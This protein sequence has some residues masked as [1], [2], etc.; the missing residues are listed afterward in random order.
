MAAFVYPNTR[1]EPAT[2]SAAGRH[3]PHGPAPYLPPQFPEGAQII[4]SPDH[5]EGRV[6]LLRLSFGT[7]TRIEAAAEALTSAL[8]DLR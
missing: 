4:F 1:L 6:P 7:E 2:F 3:N 8:G 5:I